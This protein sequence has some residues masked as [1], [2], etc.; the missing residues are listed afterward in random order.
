MRAGRPALRTADAR[1]KTLVAVGPRDA[2]AEGLGVGARVNRPRELSQRGDDA[3][4]RAHDPRV[5]DQLGDRYAKARDCR[6]VP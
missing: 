3:C 6:R 4:A 2:Q 5:G 1:R